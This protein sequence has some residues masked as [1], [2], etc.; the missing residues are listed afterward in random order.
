MRKRDRLHKQFKTTGDTNIG[1]EYRQ[2]RKEIVSHIR[3]AKHQKAEQLEAKVN[4]MT[5]S[6]KNWWSLS[7]EA[8]G[9]SK[10]E[11]A[12]PLR[13]NNRLVNGDSEKAD[14][15]NN[16]FASQTKLDPSS[17]DLPPLQ[18]TQKQIEQLVI[19]PE[20]VFRILDNL[21]VEKATGPDGIGNKILKEAAISF[22]KPL[23]ELFNL[24]LGLGHFPDK[25]KLAQ[26]IPVF[27]N[28]DPTNC[29]NYR[30][31]SLLPCVS[32]VFERLLF[33][34]IFGYLRVNKWDCIP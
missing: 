17:V 25:W 4:Q 23:S 27:K 11:L 29:T 9:L 6:S 19:Q 12:G 10:K 33:N 20:D 26:I 14:L 5:T 28:G 8:L 2:C 32:K 16:F 3:K 31:I 30:P 24:C 15:L 7:K 21:N 34:H 18:A 22:A 13:S 1:L